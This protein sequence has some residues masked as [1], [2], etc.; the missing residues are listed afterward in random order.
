MVVYLKLI[1]YQVGAIICSTNDDGSKKLNSSFEIDCD[2]NLKSE[3]FS[4]FEINTNLRLVCPAGCASDT[5]P[6]YGTGIY[7]DNSSICK[8]ALHSG[9]IKDSLGGTVEV[10]VEPGRKNYNGST[11]YNIDSL[12]YSEE[13]SRSFRVKKF[14]PYCP[15]DKIKEYIK[16]NGKGSSFVSLGEKVT[17][18]NKGLSI[19]NN[20]AMIKSNNDANKNNIIFAKEELDKLIRSYRFNSKNSYISSRRSNANNIEIVT[21]P[22][23]EM[24]TQEAI[25]SIQTTNEKDNKQLESFNNI[26]QEFKTLIG[27]VLYQVNI[28]NIDKELGLKN[29]NTVFS[30]LNKRVVNIRKNIFEIGRKTQQI[31]SKTEHLLRKAQSRIDNFLLMDQFLED[32]SSQ[33]VLNNYQIFNNKKGIGKPPKWEYYMYNLDG[34]VKTIMQKDPF[35]DSRTVIR[36]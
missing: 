31:V 24:T 29:Q 14:N 25:V 30:T 12:D 23:A 9:F 33:S 7:T 10:N 32:Y 20:G 1:E 34:H 22:Q 36:Y 27:K 3:L 35:I 21:S 5:S 4:N 13:W 28:L 16:A 26:G 6:I 19:V 18:K 17:L 8:A 2:T 15:I 11:K